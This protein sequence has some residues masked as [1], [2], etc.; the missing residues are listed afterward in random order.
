MDEK[1]VSRGR[2]FRPDSCPVEKASPSLAMPA[3]RPSRPRLTAAEGPRKSRRAS[4]A[5]EARTKATL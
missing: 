1:S 5:P 4:C 2:A 3:A